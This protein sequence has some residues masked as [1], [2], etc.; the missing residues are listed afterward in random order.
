M[1]VR[2]NLSMA[3]ESSGTYVNTESNETTLAEQVVDASISRD[4]FND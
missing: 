4:E 2:R 1:T 3:S